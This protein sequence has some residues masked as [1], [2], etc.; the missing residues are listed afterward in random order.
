[1]T[2]FSGKLGGLEIQSVNVFHE[3]AFNFSESP[4]VY[5]M[6][7]I[8]DQESI[9]VSGLQSFSIFLLEKESVATV[10]V[11]Q[12]NGKLEQ[13]DVICAEN[14]AATLTVSGGSAVFLI[15]GVKE[16]TKPPALTI[17]PSDKIYKVVKPW[18]HELWINGEHPG[19]CL[20]E[21]YIKKG[22]RTSLQYH[23][24]KYET[25]VLF[26]GEAL[27]HYKKNPEIPNDQVENKDISQLEILPV[28][29]I[30]VEPHTLHRIEAKSDIMLYEVS[31][32]H[33]DDVIR[34]QDDA[35][36]PNGRISEEHKNK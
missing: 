14:H 33:L 29:M 22:T 28:S 12:I 6:R 11:P 27:V 34:I 3:G 20:K 36:R 1:M 32:P 24:L 8:R 13:G 9:S 35:R 2:N 26:A 25:N 15:A 23:R 10:T 18:G 30:N 5:R 4:Y 16:S 17:T 19:Y 21:V 7:R 31:T